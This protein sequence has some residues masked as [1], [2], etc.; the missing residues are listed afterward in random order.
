[1][2]SLLNV[3]PAIVLL[4]GVS[5]HANASLIGDVVNGQYLFPNTTTVLSN[6]GTQTI[7]N[8]TVFIFPFAEVTATFTNRSRLLM[9]MLGL[10]R[11]H[12][13]ESISRSY[14]ARRSRRLLKI[15]PVHRC[16]PRAAC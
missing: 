4:V 13:T 5:G 10:Q 9:P 2:K 6:A 1:M 15:P 8:G 12:S 7:A 16:S 11:P 3:L 14:Q